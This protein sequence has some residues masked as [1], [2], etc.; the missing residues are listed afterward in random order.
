MTAKDVARLLKISL[1]S[2]YALKHD[3]GY[4]QIGGRVRFT[5]DDVDQFVSG[6]RVARKRPAP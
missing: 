6:C 3:I 1:R 5:K 4:V 2:A